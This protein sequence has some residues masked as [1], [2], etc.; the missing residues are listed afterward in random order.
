MTHYH[1]F[2]VIVGVLLAVCPAYSREIFVSPEGD[3]R[4]SGAKEM[5]LQTVNKALEEVQAGDVVFLRGGVYDCRAL[6]RLD[7]NGQAENPITLSAY[8]GEVPVLDFQNSGRSSPGIRL[9][10]SSWR[11]KGLVIQRA[12]DNGVI[13]YGAN[14]CLEQMVTCYNGDSGTQLH[15]GAAHNLIKNC[16]SY[17]NYDAGNHGEN[18]DGFAAKFTL[19][20]GNTFVGCRSWGN[21]DDGYDLWEAGAGV[22]FVNCWA[23]R[24]GVHVLIGCL[25]YDLPHNGIDINGNVTGV[26]IYNC[27]CAANKGPNFYFDEHSSLHV[28]RNNLSYQ[29]SVTVY[30]EID[31]TH[32]SWNG[33]S[34]KS[35]DFRGL[36][37]NG[38]DGP[39]KT[40][41]SLP[42]LTFLRPGPDS[43]LIDAGVDVGQPYAGL[44]P[45]LGAFEFLEGDSNG[46]GAIDYIDLARLVSQ[47]LDADPGGLIDF[48]DF[49]K[50]A[51]DWRR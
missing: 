49:S 44:A 36:D 45:D 27:T 10:G 11:L 47:W 23:F 1:A 9:A 38:I 43:T 34:I 25:A 41:G 29:G 12:G 16:D 39:R 2:S 26:T 7:G 21:S 6:I 50:L 42:R 8:P 22:T 15:T 48:I 19:G 33:F 24:N 5:P 28:M 46:D 32:N 18:A 37:P 4:D 14:N 40:D 35:A 17:A 20:E 30:N 3:D 13:V 31:D 51:E